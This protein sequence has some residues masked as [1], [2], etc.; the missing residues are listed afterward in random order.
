[1]R[2]ELPFIYPS[3]ID[4]YS[5]DAGRVAVQSAYEFQIPLIIMN[6]ITLSFDYRIGNCGFNWNYYN[7][8][9]FN[10][11]DITNDI[12]QF[13]I[14]DYLVQAINE[15]YQIQLWIDHYYISQSS[16][17]QKR[18]FIHDNASIYGYDLEDGVFFVAD[19]FINGKFSVL[20]IPFNEIRES[21]KNDNHFKE[22]PE[23]TGISTREA[24]SR[25]AIK[26][27]LND[28]YDK[29]FFTIENLVKILQGFLDGKYLI[30]K[31]SM[32]DNNIVYGIRV[33]DIL[34]SFLRDRDIGKIEFNI[35]SLQAIYNQKC[36]IVMLINYINTI[37]ELENA[38]YLINI[39]EE[40]K[41][42]WVFIRY[43]LIK[44]Q[45]TKNDGILDMMIQNIQ[46]TMN[47]E[48]SAIQQ[49]IISLKAIDNVSLIKV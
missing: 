16:V 9:G 2:K 15:G 6:H 27:T 14:V 21:R 19:N 7:N 1:M 35:R 13:D 22:R 49:V 20:S 44:F 28:N 31:D 38:I 30:D 24:K 34:I 4:C 33:Y 45:I 42:D 8:S 12:E 23:G 46:N 40:I 39:F 43:Q 5:G 32:N 11:I 37:V 17:Y 3:V 25:P 18:H 41:K 47:K 10:D 26:Y 48:V 36:I 29:S